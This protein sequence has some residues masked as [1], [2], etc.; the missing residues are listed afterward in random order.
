LVE[1]S[2]GRIVE[3][4]NREWGN[5]APMA[6]S[7]TLTADKSTFYSDRRGKNPLRRRGH[8]EKFLG[9]SRG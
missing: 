1:W 8:K 6:G 5:W 9:V 3:L 7:A 4:L 2:N